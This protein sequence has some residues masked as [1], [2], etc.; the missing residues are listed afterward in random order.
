MA[1]AHRLDHAAA[2][3]D[4]VD[5]L[6][7]LRA[8]PEVLERRAG[9]LG[10]CLG[11]TLAYMAAVEGDPDVAVAYY[12][13]GIPAALDAAEQIA[14]PTIMHWGGTDPFIARDR[15]DAVAAVAADHDA[16]E[17]HA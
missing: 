1:A 11:G 5:A 12:G 13:S 17:C 14:C 8:M 10:F 7:V 3:G 16:I 9:V 15:V 2:V 4:A 6:E